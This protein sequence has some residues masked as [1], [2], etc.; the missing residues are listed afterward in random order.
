MK[1][2]RRIKV[3][4]SLP[5]LIIPFTPLAIYNDTPEE[6]IQE[7]ILPIKSVVFRNIRSDILKIR[8]TIHQIRIHISNNT[9]FHCLVPILQSDL[10]FHQDKMNKIRSKIDPNT[11]QK[12]TTKSKSTKKVRNYTSNTVTRKKLRII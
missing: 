11:L 7:K 8:E 2:K 5:P 1:Q 9:D 6:A 12:W 4:R 3:D 10:Q